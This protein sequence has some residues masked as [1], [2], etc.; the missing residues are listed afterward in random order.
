MSN[1]IHLKRKTAKNPQT[2][3][4]RHKKALLALGTATIAL[5][6]AFQAERMWVNPPQIKTSSTTIRRQPATSLNPK[7]IE[8]EKK[9]LEKKLIKKSKEHA[10]LSKKIEAYNKKIHSE[11]K[12]AFQKQIAPFYELEKR[13]LNAILKAGDEGLPALKIIRNTHSNKISNE[14]IE[15]I[16]AKARFAKSA[17]NEHARIWY[18]LSKVKNRMRNDEDFK[19]AILKIRRKVERD[20]VGTNAGPA[21]T[22]LLKIKRG[23]TKKEI[24]IRERHLQHEEIFAQMAGKERE[25]IQNLNKLKALGLLEQ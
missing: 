13:H 14:N 1:V 7:K 5:T 22:L 8:Q 17:P 21:T 2:F 15:K 9:K 3:L 6:A 16:K 23:Q 25:I 20:K 18:V 12:E 11:Y 24:K 10:V 4:Q 19:E